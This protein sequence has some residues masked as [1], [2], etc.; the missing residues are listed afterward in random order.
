M[1]FLEAIGLVDIVPDTVESFRTAL[2][3]VLPA[4]RAWARTK[5]AA[6]GPDAVALQALAEADQLALT[7][8]TN[9]DHPINMKW[10]RRGGGGPKEAEER[11]LA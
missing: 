10:R 7:G 9:Q 4:A 2:D 1:G 6:L 3:F 11:K 8:K 5:A